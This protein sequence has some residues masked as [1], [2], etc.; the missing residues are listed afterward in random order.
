MAYFLT[1]K[2][3]ILTD[4]LIAQNLPAEILEQ[5]L[6]CLTREHAKQIQ[7]NFTDG[8]FG[9]LICFGYKIIERD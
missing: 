1:Y 9:D 6:A 3:A 8:D 4:E 2:T 7:Q 5:E